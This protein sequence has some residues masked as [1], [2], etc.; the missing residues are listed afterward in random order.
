VVRHLER[1][2]DIDIYFSDLVG[3]EYRK[4]NKI[5]LAPEKVKFTY[6]VSILYILDIVGTWRYS[7]AKEMGQDGCVVTCNRIFTDIYWSGGIFVSGSV[8][9]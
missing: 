9:I 6:F 1:G 2:L 7:Y 5:N 4:Y 3:H 8:K